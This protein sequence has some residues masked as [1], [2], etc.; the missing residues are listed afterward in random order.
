[1]L[2]VNPPPSEVWEKSGL[3]VGSFEIASEP[4][5]TSGVSR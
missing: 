2:I 5:L 3:L 4:V 1:L